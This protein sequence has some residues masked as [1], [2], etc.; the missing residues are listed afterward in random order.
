MANKRKSDPK[1]N[2]KRLGVSRKSDENKTK[3]GVPR[4]AQA[5]GAS[6]R[7]RPSEIEVVGPVAVRAR[8]K[9]TKEQER[10]VPRGFKNDPN[11]SQSDSDTEEAVTRTRTKRPRYKCKTKKCGKM[12]RNIR[13]LKRHTK[14]HRQHNFFSCRFCDRW[15]LDRL[16]QFLI[17][18]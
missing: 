11:E 9:P 1:I 5:Q 7:G 8:K 4:S 16:V 2:E 13:H 12:Y 17:S 3:S 14:D 10:L 15:G 18:F 6:K